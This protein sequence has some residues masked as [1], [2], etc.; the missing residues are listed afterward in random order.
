MVLEDEQEITGTSKSKNR[1]QKSYKNKKYSNN[2]GSKTSSVYGN[3]RHGNNSN[4]MYNSNHSNSQFNSMNFSHPN[5]PPPGMSAQQNP[6]HFMHY[7]NPGKGGNLRTGKQ[8]YAM[9]QNGELNS[10]NFDI[11]DIITKEQ[12]NQ[13]KK[14][15]AD[16]ENQQQIAQTAKYGNMFNSNHSG[17]GSNNS[18]S[19]FHLNKMFLSN[20]PRYANQ[21]Q[22]YN[23]HRGNH[24]QNQKNTNGLA[25]SGTDQKDKGLA[26]LVNE[27]KNTRKGS[28]K[29]GFSIF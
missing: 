12:M 2:N 23:Q 16:S 15:T 14:Q 21:Q 19:N 9:N 27:F 1:S 10:N 28:T 3:N 11:E 18:G 20:Q 13:S 5:M 6:Q 8:N 29:N 17:F 22:Q 26:K 25:K 7:S 4:Q 24:P